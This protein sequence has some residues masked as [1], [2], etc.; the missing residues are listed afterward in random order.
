MASEVGRKLKIL[1]DTTVI[2]GVRTKSMTLAGEPIDVTTDDDEGKRKLL[3]ES[4]TESIDLS[5]E[6]L[7]K[8]ENLIAV[9]AG[10]GTRIESYTIELPWGG[11]IT[12]Q[13][14]LNNVDLGAEHTDAI[15]FSAE[16][17]SAGSWT[18]TPP[19]P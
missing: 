12:G 13:F 6:G 15:T 4:A 18:Y 8:D 16:I 7:T 1:R 5:V 14:R 11:E 19:A 9:A 2:A 17:H 10:G 3:E